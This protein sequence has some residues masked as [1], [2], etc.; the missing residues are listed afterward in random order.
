[1][2]AHTGRGGLTLHL[3]GPATVPGQ[4]AEGEEGGCENRAAEAISAAALGPGA[5]TPARIDTTKVSATS[6]RGGQVLSVYWTVQQSPQ[7]N[8]SVTTE[9]PDRGSHFIHVG[10]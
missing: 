6:I 5:A 10:V 4:M 7:T 9:Q 8:P 2:R 1:M 3:D